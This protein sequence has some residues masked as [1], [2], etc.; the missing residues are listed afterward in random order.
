MRNSQLFHEILESESYTEDV[1]VAK[2]VTYE[3]KRS[4]SGRKKE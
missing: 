1:E 4:S 3:Q 2:E